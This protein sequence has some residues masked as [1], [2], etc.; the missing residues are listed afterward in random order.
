[1]CI[2]KDSIHTHFFNCISRFPAFIVALAEIRKTNCFSF[3]N[4]LAI[5]SLLAAKFVE[6]RYALMLA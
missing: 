6:M 3:P 2:T 4:N 5:F 1:M